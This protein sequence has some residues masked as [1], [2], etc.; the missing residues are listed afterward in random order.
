[1]IRRFI[2]AFVLSTGLILDFGRAE[3]QGALYLSPPPPGTHFEFGG[4]VGERIKAVVDNWLIPAPTAN[5]GMTEMFQVRDRK[6]VPDLVPWAGEFVGKYLIS[7]IQML[8]MSDS[9]ELRAVVEDTIRRTIA[10][11]DEDGYLGPFRKEERLLG[12]WDLWGHYHIILAMLMWHEETGDEAAFECAKK[13]GDFICKIYLNTDKRPID[14]GSTEMNLA[15][16]H[17]LG[18]LYRATNDQKYLDMMRVIEEDWKK[19]GDYFRQ[20][21]AG[22]PFYRTP[23]PRWESLHDLQGLGELY[24]I[25]GNEDYK[26]AYVNLWKSIRKYDR[27]NTGGFSTGEQAIGNPYTPGAIETC[28]TIAWSAITRDILELTGD[29]EAADELELSLYNSILGSLHPSGRW[30]TYNTPMDGKREASAHTIV[31]QS[32]AGTPE[33]NCCSVN[34][35]R[36]IGM[37]SDWAVMSSGEDSFDLNY[38]GPMKLAI[39]IH[40]DNQ[41]FIETTTTFPSDGKVA[42]RATLSQPIIKPLLVSIRCPK[43]AKAVDYDEGGG[44]VTVRNEDK[45][46]VSLILEAGITTGTVSIEFPM[47]LRTLLGDGAQLGRLSLYKG[48]LLLA[49]E[50][51]DNDYDVNDLAALDFKD[52]VLNKFANVDANPA[53]VRLNFKT[54]SGNNAVLRDFASA[55]TTGTEYATWLPVEN[56]PPPD[57]NLEYPSDGERIPVG[58]NRFTWSGCKH[59]GDWYY[60]IEIAK[61]PRFNEIVYAT[62]PLWNTAAVVRE[63]LEDGSQYFWRVGAKDPGGTILSP[64]QSFTVDAS[65][66]NDF[67]DD[68]ATYEFRADDLI[69]GDYLDG[70]AAPVYG[71]IDLAEG[72]SPTPGCDGKPD[73]AI[74]FDG[75]GQVRYRTPGFPTDNYALS[76]WFRHDALQPHLAQVFSAWSKG[77]D[78]PLRIVIDK[79]KVYAR[80]EGGPGANSKG[81]PVELGKWHHIAAVKAGGNLKFF[82]DGALVGSTGAPAI[83]PTLSK[84]VSLGSNPHHTGDEHFIGAIDDFALWARALGDDEVHALAAAP[85]QLEFTASK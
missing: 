49:F 68:P 29:S 45:L 76:I 32:R 22:V 26:T 81:A 8:R 47:D 77:G 35:P 9:K 30:C 61:S 70:K 31:F 23:N 36:G 11:Q 38:L 80:I 66:P 15:V 48:P 14:A 39:P 59:L 42:V 6:P 10:G 24:R 46:H 57:I 82:V 73:S 58:T 13:M 28:C 75:T 84:D 33:L 67:V 44:S 72:L 40:E 79:D 65:L 7:A 18:K 27:H 52:F 50:Q 60:V 5:P 56:A 85:P 43:W 19:A 51:A 64:V 69:V 53:V 71:H 12:H 2:I 21:L 37:L 4:V 63:P 17:G 83:V 55:G 41:L 62:K 1:M 25:T 74:A 3:S 34:G 54:K 78:D 20:G 16:I